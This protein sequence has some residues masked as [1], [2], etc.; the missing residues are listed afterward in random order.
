MV[1]A[2]AMVCHDHGFSFL[3]LGLLVMARASFE[4]ML[5][6]VDGRACFVLGACAGARAL[7]MMGPI[8]VLCLEG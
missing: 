1:A 4:Q 8:C 7:L 2:C 3:A 6:L 5:S